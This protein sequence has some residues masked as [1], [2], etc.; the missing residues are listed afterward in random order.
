MTR[1]GFTESAAPFRASPKFDAE[2]LLLF[3]ARFAAWLAARAASADPSQPDDESGARR[4]DVLDEATRLVLVTPCK[5]AWQVWKKFE[6][7]EE[8]ITQGLRDGMSGDPL[9]LVAIGA[10]KCDLAFLDL[11]AEA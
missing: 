10:I 5:M 3:N 6:V 1:D 11:G 9:A 8:L 2:P 7:L 4:G